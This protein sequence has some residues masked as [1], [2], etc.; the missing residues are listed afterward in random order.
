MSQ[1]LQYKNYSGSV[2]FSADDHLLHGRLLGIR[3]SVAYEGKDVESL[4]ANFRAAVDEYLEFCEAEGKVPDRPFKGS[5][6]VRVGF[7][8]HKRIALFAEEQNETLNGVV[9]KAIESYLVSHE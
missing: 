5:F 6:N 3:D 2:E 4:E 9:S 8:L 1:S 7:D